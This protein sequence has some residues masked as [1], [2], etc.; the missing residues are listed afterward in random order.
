VD[1]YELRVS[2]TAKVVLAGIWFGLALL[3]LIADLVHGRFGSLGMLVPLMVGLVVLGLLSRYRI[4][5]AGGM[6]TYTTPWSTTAVPLGE[7]EGAHL[8]S[9]RKP[10]HP[11]LSLY[12]VG[13]GVERGGVRNDQ[14]VMV[15][16]A[17][18]FD[19]AGIR[20]LI[21]ILESGPHAS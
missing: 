1:S 14:P 3:W 8:S 10:H 6:L 4:T 2:A 13:S 16:N 19:R 11:T 17:R 9:P 20:R 15:I 12:V 7:V 5:V 18:L 21:Q